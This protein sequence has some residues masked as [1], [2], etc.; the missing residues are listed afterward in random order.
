MA[1]AAQEADDGFSSIRNFS[2]SDG[3]VSPGAL[4]WATAG[5][6]DLA[7]V[8]PGINLPISPG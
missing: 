5:E 8:G 3:G 4:F 6:T 7:L 2:R 1:I